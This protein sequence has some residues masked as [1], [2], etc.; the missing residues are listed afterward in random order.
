MAGSMLLS[1]SSTRLRNLSTEDFTPR[2]RSRMLYFIRCPMD[3]QRR[4]VGV[5]LRQQPKNEDKLLTAHRTVRSH[6]Q[7]LDLCRKDLSELKCK[8][9]FIPCLY[10]RRCLYVSSGQLAK[11]GIGPS[12]DLLWS[13]L[14]QY[15][16]RQH[17]IR[18]QSLLCRGQ[19]SWQRTLK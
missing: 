16:I 5:E 6:Q 3:A 12:L 1:Y 14:R 18:Q 4:T 2:N 7:H 10:L 15:R 13:C 9:G 17:R 19:A 11:C 8:Y